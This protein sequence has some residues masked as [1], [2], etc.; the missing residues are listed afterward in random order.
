MKKII[1]NIL[2]RTGVVAVFIALFALPFYCGAKYDRENPYAEGEHFS[3]RIIIE[4]GF[5]YKYQKGA[6]VQI[7]NSD[8]T[9]L[10]AGK[11]IY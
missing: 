4:N 9:P 11:K 10:R 2:E 7:F 5:V 6:T 1:L 8:G 3:Y